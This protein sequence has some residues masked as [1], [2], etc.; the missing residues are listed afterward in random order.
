MLD[1]PSGRGAPARLA[2]G[3][4]AL[5]LALSRKGAASPPRARLCPRGIAQGKISNRVFVCSLR[6]RVAYKRR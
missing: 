1:A 3:I 6:P 4:G 2:F 5:R